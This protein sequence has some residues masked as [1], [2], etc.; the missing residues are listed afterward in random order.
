MVR[1]SPRLPAAIEI[2]SASKSSAARMISCAG[3]PLRISVWMRG[4]QPLNSAATVSTAAFASALKLSSVITRG[5]EGL[6]SF[7]KGAAEYGLTT[8][9][10]VTSRRHPT[11]AGSTS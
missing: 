8:A 1:L 11:G 3:D 4:P 9:S 6:I 5:L 2:R 7:A 10:T